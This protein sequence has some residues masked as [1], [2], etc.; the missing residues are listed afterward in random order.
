MAAN[1]YRVMPLCL[2]QNPSFLEASKEELRTLLALIEAEGDIRSEDVLAAMAGVSVPR[3][4]SALALWEECGVISPDDGILVTASF[5][6]ALT[7][8]SASRKL[9]SKSDC[10]SVNGLPL[11]VGSIHL[12]FSIK[13]FAGSASDILKLWR[14]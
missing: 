4:K 11:S 8:S 3:C 10:V 12:P 6:T 7:A 9:M 2:S 14:R 5:P 13:S 1:K